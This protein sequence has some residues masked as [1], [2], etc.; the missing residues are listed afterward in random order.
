L[1]SA[2][3]AAT[4][5]STSVEESVR[6]WRGSGGRAWR[7]RGGEREGEKARGIGGRTGN[8]AATTGEGD[9]IEQRKASSWALAPRS[10]LPLF[11]K[12]DSVCMM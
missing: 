1:T 7:C 9:R 8:P 5:S 12:N 2:A 6:R 10:L 4:L 11:A 3:A